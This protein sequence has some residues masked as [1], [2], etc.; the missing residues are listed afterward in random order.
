MP[1]Q[2]IIQESH[3]EFSFNA[4]HWWSIV[5]DKHPAHVKINQTEAKAIDFLCL[6]TK[7]TLF[8]FEVKN[9]KGHRIENKDRDLSL[10]IAQKVRD[11]IA[12]MVGFARNYA[13]I[14]DETEWRAVLD[15][16]TKPKKEIYIIVWVEEDCFQNNR[17]K[18]GRQNEQKKFKTKLNWLTNKVFVCNA[19]DYANIFNNFEGFLVKNLQ[20]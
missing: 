7:H 3:L 16:L 4:S 15:I 8:L 20:R 9:F 6:Y 2:S 13:N 19:S 18:I 5:Y 17:Q 10:E 1:H 14:E 12:G 11:S